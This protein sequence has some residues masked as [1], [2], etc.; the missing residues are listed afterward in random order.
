MAQMKALSLLM[1]MI[2]PKIGKKLKIY[3]FSPKNGKISGFSPFPVSAHSIPSDF[4][5]SKETLFNKTTFKKIKKVRRPEENSEIDE[6]VISPYT[7][8]MGAFFRQKFL[9]S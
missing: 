7:K 4:I 8:C 9:S 6:I 2:K 3:G 5:C 1:T